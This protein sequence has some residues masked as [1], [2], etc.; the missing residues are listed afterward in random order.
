[1]YTRDPSGPFFIGEII[2]KEYTIYGSPNCTYC[3]QAMKLLE[4]NDMNYSYMDAA[5]SMYFQKEFV[6]RGIRS[7]PQIFVTDDGPTD[8]EQRHVGGFEELMQ[9][10]MA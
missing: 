2:M 1:M 5:S 7:V 9:E 8:R 4:M 6:D 3:D 10:L